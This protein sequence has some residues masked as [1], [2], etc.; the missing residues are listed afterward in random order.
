M[1][2]VDI[3]KNIFKIQLSDT[4]DYIFQLYLTGGLEE[5]ILLILH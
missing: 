3:L 1:F 4:R 2:V 5:N